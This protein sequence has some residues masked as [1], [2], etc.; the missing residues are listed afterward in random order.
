MAWIYLLIAGAL[1]VFWAIS[2]KYTEGFSKLWPTLVTVGGMIASFYFLAY[3]L[4]TIPVGTGYAV[5]TGI[6]AAGT[7][8]LG[9]VL[10]GESAASSRLGRGELLYALE[11]FHNDGPWERGDDY[12]RLNG[13]LRYSRGDAR[14]G[15][16]A[17]FMGYDGRWNSTDQVP[18]RAVADGRIGRFGL[19][20]PSDGGRAH[21]YSLSF[22]GQ[23]AGAS[24]L[25]RW[26]LACF[27]FWR[28][29][30]SWQMPCFW[31][32]GPPRLT[33]RVT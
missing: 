4:K 21:R 25:A 24:S 7:A 9:I 31:S 10:F 13:V 23:R 8:L 16:S 32:S 22:E 33:P 3:A 18:A 26:C 12:R 6:G 2:L 28:A 27:S 14:T 20:D 5:W 17:T 1:E 15:L 29:P 19:V 11:A 30:R